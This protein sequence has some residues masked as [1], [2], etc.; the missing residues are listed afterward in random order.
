MRW[1]AP[2][3]AAICWGER[4]GESPGGTPHMNNRSF[5]MRMKPGVGKGW[6]LLTAGLTWCAVGVLLIS[7]ALEWFGAY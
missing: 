5:V 7:Y 2:R 4:F 3:F 1:M 6:L